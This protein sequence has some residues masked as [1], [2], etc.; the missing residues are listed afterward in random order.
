MSSGFF[1]DCYLSLI[2]VAFLQLWPTAAMQEAVT[3]QMESGY[4]AGWSK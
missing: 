2:V 3:K 4:V 1:A